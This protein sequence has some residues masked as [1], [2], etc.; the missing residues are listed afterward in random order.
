MYRN[1]KYFKE[2]VDRRR[3]DNASDNINNKIPNTIDEIKEQLYWLDIEVDDYKMGDIDV[4]DRY[5]EDIL[6]MIQDIN[7]TL[8]SLKNRIMQGINNLED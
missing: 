6:D 7:Y 3:L 8:K 1:R 5:M 2:S 4:S